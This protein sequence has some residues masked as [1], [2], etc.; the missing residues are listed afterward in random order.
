MYDSSQS[1][2]FMHRT[3]TYRSDVI[4]PRWERCYEPPISSGL[5]YLGEKDTNDV[6]NIN[7]G[8]QDKSNTE[9]LTQLPQSIPELYE[10]DEVDNYTQQRNAN[11][12][13]ASSELRMEQRCNTRAGE[14]GDPGENSPTSCIVQQDFHV[15]KC[16]SDPAGNQT[17]GHRAGRCCWLEGFLGDLPFPPPLNS[18]AAPSSPHF[19]RIGS[20]YDKWA[21]NRKCGSTDFGIL[22]YKYNKPRSDSASSAKREPIRMD[23][24]NP[25]TWRDVLGYEGCQQH[26][27]RLSTGRSAVIVVRRRSTWGP[28]YETSRPIPYTTPPPYLY[29]SVSRTH[30]DQEG[31]Q[32]RQSAYPPP[33]PHVSPV[34]RSTQYLQNSQLNNSPLLRP[35]RLHPLQVDWAASAVSDSRRLPTGWSAVSPGV[36]KVDLGAISLGC[37]TRKLNPIKVLILLSESSQLKSRSPSP[38]CTLNALTGVIFT[39]YCVDDN[40]LARL[41]G[42]SMSASNPDS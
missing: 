11:M 26:S 13:I 22:L 41:N 8:R 28:G 38:H 33:F 9:R 20:L 14:M 2:G 42:R 35:I 6:K 4:R 34:H 37:M 10:D 32:Y 25:H 23:Y 17:R 16:G 18:S 12:A 39:H 30:S 3:Q 24:V 36:A 29:P 19:T 7:S 5:V 21:K 40:A 15:R 31:S 27:R 1:F